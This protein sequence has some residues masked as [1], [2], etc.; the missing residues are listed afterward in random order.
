MVKSKTK[1]E[2]QSQKKSNPQLV[3]TIRLAKKT[4]SKFWLEIAGALSSPRRNAIALNLNEIE[5]IAKEGD[6]IVIPG[7]ILSQGELSKKIAVIA[8]NFSDKA[9]EKL[10]KTKCLTVNILDEIKKNPE[11]KGLKIIGK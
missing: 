7:K 6:S 11:A 9:R 10:L 8:F 3:E 4:G 1:I 2:Q 5:K